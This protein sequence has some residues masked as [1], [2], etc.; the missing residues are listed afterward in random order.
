MHKLKLFNN[1]FIIFFGLEFLIYIISGMY[2]IHGIKNEQF[3]NT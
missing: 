1:K 2:K 3:T